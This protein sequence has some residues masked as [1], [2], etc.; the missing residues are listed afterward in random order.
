ME[1][2]NRIDQEIKNAEE[3][4][5]RLRERLQDEEYRLFLLRE[6]QI[7]NIGLYARPTFINAPINEDKAITSPP[8]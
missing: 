8:R 2:Q 1:S 3:S 4:I 5:Q 6:M 7:L